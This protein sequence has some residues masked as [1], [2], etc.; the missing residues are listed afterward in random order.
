MIETKLT[1]DTGFKLDNSYARLPKIFFKRQNPSEVPTPSLVALN[2]K[3]IKELGLN[4]NLLKSADGIGIFAGNRLLEGSIPIAEAYAGHQ[5]G[6]FTMLGDGR[7]VLLGEHVTSLGEKFDVQLKGAGRTPYSRGGDGKA[8]LGPMLREYII[9]E[10]MNALGIPTTRSLAVVKTGEKVIREGEQIGAIL[11]RVA[12]SHI[13]VGTFQYAANWGTIEDIKVLA[14]YTLERHFKVPSTI[15]NKYLFLLKEVIKRQ[16]NLIAKWQ[17]VGFI[18]GVMNTD[19]MA[20]SGETIDYGPCAFMDAYDPST[21]FSSIDVNGRYAYGNQPYIA[22]WNLARFAE[23]LIPLLHNSQEKA[24]KLAEKEVSNFPNLYHDKWFSGMKAKLGIFNEELEDAN[25]I[26]SLL[27]IMEKYSADYTNTFR[28]LTL[29]DLEDIEMFNSKE[30]KKWNTLWVSRLE[31]QEQTKIEIKELMKRSNPSI[32]PRNH[33]VEE[34]LE[35]AIKQEDYSVM[36]RFLDVL[37]RPYDYSKDQEE[38]SILPEVSN[39]KYRTYCGT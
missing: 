16:A 36:E 22:S 21:V 34:A 39:C 9:S 23:T 33:R 14:D 6:Y 31:R 17:L 7:A 8:A 19:N 32:I 2:S 11:T 27:N 37:S 29:D 25:L 38:Y 24:I 35:G 30:F 18:H 12:S 26:D 1:V 4:E 13:R 3:L 15:E 28:S 20:I 5:F 10:A